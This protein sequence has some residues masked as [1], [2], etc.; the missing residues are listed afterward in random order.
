MALV[1]GLNPN[2]RLV[3]PDPDELPP[4]EDIVV[5][6]APEGADVE[7]LDDSGNVIQIEHDD[8]S[9]TISLDGKPVEEVTFEKVKVNAKIDAKKF[10]VTK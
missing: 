4:G 8:G 3:Q 2:I 5:E 10:T 9:I 7:H 1:P 6:N